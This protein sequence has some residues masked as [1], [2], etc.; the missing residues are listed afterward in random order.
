MER[1]NHISDALKVNVIGYGSLAFTNISNNYHIVNDLIQTTCTTI[2]V[3]FT[4]AYTIMKFIKALKNTK[5]DD[6]NI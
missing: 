5:P 4:A 1:L 3:L 2:I 6:K